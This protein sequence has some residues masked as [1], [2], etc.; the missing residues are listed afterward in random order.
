MLDLWEVGMVA[1][2][3]S[4]NLGDWAGG[5]QI[6]KLPRQPSDTEILCLKLKNKDWG[7]SLVQKLHTQ[8]AYEILL[9]IDKII[10][11]PKKIQLMDMG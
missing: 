3:N 9:V 8:R 6:I 11:Y 2:T 7:C 4:S 10:A 5:S 1:N